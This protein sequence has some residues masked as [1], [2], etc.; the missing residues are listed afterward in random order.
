M[1]LPLPPGRQPRAWQLAALAACRE[2]FRSYRSIL[3]SAATGT[4]KGTLIPGL[5]QSAAM[6][7]RRCLVL[8]N[9]EELVVDLHARCQAVA[10]ARPVGMVMRERDEWNRPVIVA[11]VQSVT[12]RRFGQLGKID[13]VLTDEAHHAVAPS[14]R[15]LYAAVAER[16]PAWKHIGLTATPFRTGKDGGTSGLGDV[17]ESLVFEYG[18]ADAIEA[19]DLVPV[20]GYQVRTDLDLS[21]VTVGADGDYDADELADL[22][23]IPARNEL[24]VDQYLERGNGAPALVFAASIAHAQHLAEAFKARGVNGEAV[25]GDMDKARRRFLVAMFKDHPDAL[26]VIIS[27]DL[28]LEGFDAPKTALLLKAR[29]TRSKLIFTQLVGRGLR[30]VD[31]PAHIVDPAERRA[32]IATSSKPSCTLVDL[33]DNG[34]ALT[35]DSIADLSPSEEESDTKIRPL[36]VGDRV[37]RRHH[38]DWGCGWVLAVAASDVL[39]LVT[40]RWPPSSVHA[41]GTVSVHPRPELR[42]VPGEAAPDEEPAQVPMPPTITGIRVY[43]MVGLM[44]AGRM[45]KLAWFKDGETLTV[46]GRRRD[47]TGV[48]IH[49]RP[50]F[51]GLE[52]WEVLVDGDTTTATRRES[53]PTTGAALRWA[54]EHLRAL[55]V[56]VAAPDAPWRRKPASTGQLGMLRALGRHRDTTGMSAG[57]ASA[58]IDLAVATRAIRQAEDP[59]RFRRAE[60]VR[61]AAGNRARERRAGGVA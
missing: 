44:G 31:M 43:E 18:I 40:V 49:V 17:F 32:W 50:G 47:G 41:H 58:L 48:V 30:T 4:G 39:P 6:K 21:G 25:W 19:G 37:T 46:G 57:E 12:P 16:N 59:D 14:W 54:E 53:R 51:G 34:C 26:P 23:D 20:T 61:R 7:G 5:A 38:D 24:V 1:S 22:I 52:V 60:A 28:L 15:R 13:L 42:Y 2:G 36:L 35:L 3:V 45:P 29:P 55:G 33:V 56:D 27:R 8:T 9:R 10:D 11:S